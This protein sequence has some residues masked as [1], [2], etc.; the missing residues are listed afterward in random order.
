MFSLGFL[1]RF[2]NIVLEMEKEGIL[3]S[4]GLGNG[5]ITLILGSQFFFFLFQK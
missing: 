1:R 2:V 4:A 3:T 5:F